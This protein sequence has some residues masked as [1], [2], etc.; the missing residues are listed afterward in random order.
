MNITIKSISPVIKELVIELPKERVDEEIAKALKD[1]KS[2]AHTSVKGFRPGRVPKTIVESRFGKAIEA[3]V[4]HKLIDDSYP[5]AA[6]REAIQ[7]VAQ[8]HVEE[9]HLHRG[10]PFRYTVRVEV[11]PNVEP[12][13]YFGLDV[14]RPKVDISAEIVDREIERLRLGQ[15][16]LKPIDARTGAEKG[17]VAMVDFVGRIDGRVFRDGRAID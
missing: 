6:E 16:Q 8:A 14:E 11:R 4:A 10:E 9:Y 15:A 13:G 17:D 5:K 12:A 7:A 1:A 3:E 2:V